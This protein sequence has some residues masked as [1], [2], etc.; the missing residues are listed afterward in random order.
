MDVD[1]Q[2]PDVLRSDRN[3]TTYYFCSAECKQTFEKNPEQF[4]TSV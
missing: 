2:S 4:I 3:G 1:P